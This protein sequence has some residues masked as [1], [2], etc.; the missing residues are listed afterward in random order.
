VV[1]EVVER[2]RDGT[3]ANYIYEPATAGLREV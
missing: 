2:I 1:D 3:I